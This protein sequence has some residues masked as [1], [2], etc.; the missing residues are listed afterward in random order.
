MNLSAELIYIKKTWAS[1]V[2][3]NGFPIASLAE[4]NIDNSR[5]SCAFEHII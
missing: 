5:I 4:D 1:S 2:A 3:W